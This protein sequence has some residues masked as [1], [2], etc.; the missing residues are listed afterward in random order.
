MNAAGANSV[1]V[2]ANS[3]VAFPIG[4]EVLV[5]QIGAGATTVAGDIGVTVDNAGAVGGQWKS[6][7]LYKRGTNEW[8]QTTS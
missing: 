3:S 6:I 5:T 1:T 2:P 7:K 8:V 4:T